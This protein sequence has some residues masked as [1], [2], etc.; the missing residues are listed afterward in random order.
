MYGIHGGT[1]ECA[2]RLVGVGGSTERGL[3]RDL[4]MGETTVQVKIQTG[5]PAMNMP[6]Q[7]KC[8]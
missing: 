7:V 8:F 5:K 4:T 3:R 1:G 2:I 6:A